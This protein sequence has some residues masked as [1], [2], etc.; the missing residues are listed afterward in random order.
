MKRI[1]LTV[2]FI[3]LA[4]CVVF[5]QQ[6][7]SPLVTIPGVTDGGGQGFGAY[8]NFL[9][10]AAIGIGAFLAV[11]KII[12]AGV[13]YMTTDVINS[14]SNAKGEITG[15]L[16]GLLLI[17]GAYMILNIIN[18]K[19]VS[20]TVNF[21]QIP[22]PPTLAAPPA[23]VASTNGT[24]N[25][26]TADAAP[27]APAAGAAAGAA[28]SAT[29]MRGGCGTKADKSNT[30]NTITVM[31]VSG[32]TTD[33]A[34][35][36]GQFALSCTG[37]GSAHT[38]NASTKK[39]VCATPILG[40]AAPT[41][42]TITQLKS[43]YTKNFT[44]LDTVSQYADEKS[45]CEAKNGQVASGGTMSSLTCNLPKV[46]TYSGEALTYGAST[47]QNAGGSYSAPNCLFR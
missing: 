30:R 22:T 4:P 28:A 6:K 3:L 17:L 36:L 47:C 14:K 46:V 39:A 25:P 29:S 20:P 5:A 10:A 32:C 33:P 34:S 18:P 9:Y 42:G 38:Y 45:A 11:I 31:D 44:G 12:I 1:L 2:T 13:K 41:G 43:S 40:T 19:L 27:A 8:V 7:Y 24:T 21:Q 37:T 16:L 35:L 23:G 26:T 15:A